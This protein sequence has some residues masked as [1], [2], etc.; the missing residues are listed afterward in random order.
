[1]I[2]GRVV[3]AGKDDREVLGGKAE[4]GVCLGQ[5]WR[6]NR[7]AWALVLGRDGP[8]SAYKGNRGL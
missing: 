7:R 2:E 1:M 3:R 5:G 8:E 6:L 4:K